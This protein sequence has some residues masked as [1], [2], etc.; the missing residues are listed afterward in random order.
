VLLALLFGACGDDDSSADPDL[1]PGVD[2]AA[3]DGGLPPGTLFG[4]CADDAQ[5]Q[6]GLGPDGVCRPGADGFTG[7]S[8]SIVCADRTPCDDGVVNNFC[9]DLDGDGVSHC[10]PAC[11]NSTDCRD[12]YLCSARGELNPSEESIGVCLGYCASDEVCGAGAECSEYAGTC[13][14]EGTVPTEGAVTGEACEEDDDCISGWCLPETA[15]DGSATGWTGG[16]CLVRCELA[17]GWNSNDLFFESSFPIDCE[18]GNTC[19]P[20]GDYTARSEGVCLTSCTTDAD[21]RA[22]EGYF[23][24][25]TYE[26]GSGMR[27]FDTGVCFPME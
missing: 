12:S 13:V 2:G 9:L 10:E 25:R 19:F 21:C 4:P 11:Q 15:P 1:G 7:G 23:C 16:A 18:G 3:A 26:V 8:C 20:N 6:A 17:A 22:S 27:T 5:C 14:A 24:R